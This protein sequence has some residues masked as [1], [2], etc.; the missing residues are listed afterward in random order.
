[1]PPRPA[2]FQRP[3]ETRP[4]LHRHAARPRLLRRSLMRF[5]RSIRWRLQLWYGALFVAVLCGFGFTAFHLERARQF[6]RIDDGL[7]E[8]ISA[9]VDALRSAPG[10]DANNEP[11]IALKLS[12]QQSA[13]F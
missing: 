7:H 3:K 8:R 5:P 6:R 13:L 1:D 2:R 9:L 10:R 12:P 11:R 4:R